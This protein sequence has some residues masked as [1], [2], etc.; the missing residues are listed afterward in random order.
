MGLL[1]QLKSQA[2]QLQSQ[3]V[4]VQE[5]LAA[6]SAQVQLAFPTVTHYF[7]DLATH[8]NVIEPS[9]PS[10][11][12]DGKTPW[13]AMKLRAFQTDT[14]KKMLRDMEVFD[15]V[16][17]G[18]T[19]SPKMGVAVG[20]SVNLSF[21]PEIDRV[22]QALTFAHI[23]HVRK[24]TRHPVRHFLQSVQFDYTTQARGNVTVTADHD[25]GTLMFRI[26][27]ASGFVVTTT[28]V[29]ANRICSDLLDEVAKLILAQPSTF[30]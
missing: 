29:D 17:M 1:N 12:L 22:Q 14:R 13:P 19:I 28:A 8:L 23:E 15:Y 16:A 26:A 3:R 9:G 10:F 6:K 30:A 20:G 25:A 7:R 11:T 18:W 4:V 21:I 24:E 27:N 2:T 5:D